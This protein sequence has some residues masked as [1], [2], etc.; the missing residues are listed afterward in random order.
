MFSGDSATTPAGSRQRLGERQC[1]SADW[2]SPPL[3]RLVLDKDPLRRVP[4]RQDVDRVAPDCKPPAVNGTPFA[5]YPRH[6][7]QVNRPHVVYLCARFRD[8]SWEASPPSLGASSPVSVG[9]IAER[10]PG[11]RM[12][13]AQAGN[14]RHNGRSCP[15]RFGSSIAVSRMGK[16]R[17]RIPTPGQGRQR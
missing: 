2:L 13:L 17:R 14:L 16:A 8:W 7:R 12:A 10:L 11:G 15:G 4:H 9:E 3:I 5:N 1:L 6:Y